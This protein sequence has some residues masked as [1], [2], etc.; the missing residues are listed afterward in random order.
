MGPS[1]NVDVLGSP[2]SPPSVLRSHP[3]CRTLGGKASSEGAFFFTHSIK[4][5]KNHMNDNRY[6]A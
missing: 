6:N 3:K 5:T 1:K 2:R 4:G